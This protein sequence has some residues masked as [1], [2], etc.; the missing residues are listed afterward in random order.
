MTFNLK[1]LSEG[2]HLGMVLIYPDGTTRLVA[3]VLMPNDGD[4][5]ANVTFYDELEESYQKRLRQAYRHWRVSKGNAN[6]NSSL[7]NKNKPNNKNNQK[8]SQKSNQQR[9]KK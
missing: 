1:S 7:N 4:W 2:N 6:I 9:R 5:R 8:R 3:D